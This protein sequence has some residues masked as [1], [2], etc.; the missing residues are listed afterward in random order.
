VRQVVEASDGARSV[1]ET[2]EHPGAVVILPILR[3]LSA[4]RALTSIIC[5]SQYRH[6]IQRDIIE[7]PAGT[8]EA[9]E[10][11]LE[12][13]NREIQEEIGYAARGMMPLG[14]IYPAPGFCNEV[15]HLFVATE[16]Y[17]QRL[18]CDA[19]EEI[20][21]VELTAVEFEK[22]VAS[23]EIIDGKSLAT[24]FKARILGLI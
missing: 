12:C 16:L 22:R 15:Q 24:F 11:P 2:I 21:V 8:I 5:I 6:S 23:G 3:Q 1:Q 19:D 10:A 20:K 17:P 14:Y 7:L 18:A 13:A 9:G 4:D